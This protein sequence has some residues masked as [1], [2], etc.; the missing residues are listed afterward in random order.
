M[1]RRSFALLA[2]ALAMSTAAV[3]LPAAN[4][5][6]PPIP[7]IRLLVASSTVEAQRQG[8]WVYID[9]GAW[10]AS[11]NGAFQLNV[12][13]PDY[14]TPVGVTQVDAST[15]AVLRTLPSSVLDGW[16]GLVGFAHLSIRD[17]SAKLITRSA[18]TFCPD[19]YDVERVSDSGPAN[20]RYPY[21]C[22]A[23]PLTKSMVWGIDDGWAVSLF[24]GGYY[25]GGIRL[26][27]PDGHYSMRV[28]IGSQYADLLGISPVDMS[29]TIDLNVTSPHGR[30]S[31]KQPV[32]QPPAAEQA[33]PTVTAPD[34]ATEPDM[35][36]LPSWG[37]STYHRRGRD[38][39]SFGATAWNDGPS[40]L[41]VEGFRQ[42]D[43]PVMDAYQYFYDQNGTAV[44]RASVG[45][46]EYDAR[47]GHQH[48]HFQQ[49]A[50]Y[51]LLDGS[52][53][54]I[55]PSTKEAF[56]I[57]PT[58]ALDLTAPGADWQP[59]TVG[60]F[61]ACGSQGAI[62][63][64]ENL[65]A[66]WGDTYTQSLP[67]QAFDITDLPNGRYFIKVEVNPL[68][69]LYETNTANDTSLR[70]VILKGT[71]GNRRVVVPPWH[72]I[73]TENFCYYCFPGVASR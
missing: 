39:L 70:R 54:E 6:D 38:Y 42:P 4:A 48:W 60:L 7:S 24:G 14:S 63:V 11:V 21:Y 66:G 16:F 32:V 49:F 15:G 27:L 69:V 31:P 34:P 62:W 3:A 50:A 57:A 52:R 67:G 35:Q 73:D 20:S 68:H 13:R 64:R 44:G 9:P 12:A 1:R 29:A 30:V 22:G 25:Y 23:N 26:R 2:V 47:P 71:I 41:V 43:Q 65:E 61:S 53:T 36:A 28:W 37:I 51:S 56:C 55:V 72:G 40:P 59:W 8:K 46:L 19:V 58:D 17:S 10:I 45:T 33:V 18:Q 5:A